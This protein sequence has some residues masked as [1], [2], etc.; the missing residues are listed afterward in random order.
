MALQPGPYA[1]LLDFLTARFPHVARALWIARLQDGKVF[2]ESGSPIGIDDALH[3]PFT[4]RGKIYYFRE[5]GFEAPI[6]V[7][8]RVVFEDDCLLVIDKPSGLPVIPSGHYLQETVLV[9]Q[10]RRLGLDTLVPI[11]RIDRDTCG[12]VMLC[13]QAKHRSAYSAL[14][15]QRQVR[16]TYEAIAPFR[17]DLQFP[18]KRHTRIVAGKHF[19]LQ[20]EVAGEPNALTQID[21]IEH[22][23]SLA[24][25]RLQ[26]S[27]GRRH[28]LR[29]HMMALGIPILNDGLYPT[30]TPE[31]A[32]GAPLQLLAQ[33]LAFRDP[34]TGQMREFCS[35]ER[36]MTLEQASA[37]FASNAPK[38]A[39]G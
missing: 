7:Q 18:L 19:M 35:S 21:L 10:K 31:G 5:T 29:V 13:L 22:Q 24:R 23:R 4:G 28:Q 6:R 14:F 12:L 25:Y 17:V 8:E 34:V 39:L 1:N 3:L 30:L 16:K 15:S 33:S 11:H 32:Q 38:T 9:R 26:P 27:S 20:Q 37:Q 2:N 36:L